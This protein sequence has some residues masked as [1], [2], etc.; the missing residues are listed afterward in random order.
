[1]VGGI[2]VRIIELVGGH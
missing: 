1:V 2:S